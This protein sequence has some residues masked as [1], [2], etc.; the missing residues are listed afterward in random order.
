M[1]KPLSHHQSVANV[2]RTKPLPPPVSPTSVDDGLRKDLRKGGQL[3]EGPYV[4][5][6]ELLQ[7]AVRNRCSGIQAEPVLELCR[8]GV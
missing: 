1:C 7:L 8:P 5:H 4:T 2:G 6:G 3:A